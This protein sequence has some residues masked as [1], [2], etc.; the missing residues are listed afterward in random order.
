MTTKTK[1]APKP[2]VAGEGYKEL[3]RGDYRT[4]EISVGSNF[5][6]VFNEKAIRELADSIGKVGVLQPVILRRDPKHKYPVLVA[7]ERRL[8]A[9][10]LA[11]V[12]T[13]PGRILDITADQ[14]LEVQALENLHRKDLTPLEEARAFKALLDAKGHTL[15]QVEELAGR[16]DKSTTYIYRAV[17]LLE[18]PKDVLEKIETG[19]WTPAHGH[20]MLRV[21]KDKIKD[22]LEQADN[23]MYNDKTLTVHMLKE[24]I[25]EEVENNLDGAG[26]PKTVEYA[27]KP[28]CS[29]CSYNSGNQG[30]LFDGAEKGKCSDKTCFEAKEAQHQT[31][32]L[33]KVKKEHGENFLGIHKG[34][35]SSGD[36]AGGGIIIGSIDEKKTKAAQKNGAKYVM[37]EGGTIYVIS[38]DKAV[39]NAALGYTP[40]GGGS[41]GTMHATTPRQKFIRMQTYKALFEAARRT[42]QKTGLTQAHLAILAE[43]L[44]P[45]HYDTQMPLQ[46]IPVKETSRGYNS[47]YNYAAL[48][49]D[50]LRDLVL[51]FALDKSHSMSTVDPTVRDLGRFTNL[52]VNVKAVLDAGKKAGEVAWEAQKA[53]KKAANK[54]KP[55][56]KGRG[57]H[58]TDTT[59]TDGDEE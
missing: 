40:G 36:R 51:M 3:F 17:R 31:D 27:G 46:V 44:E 49:Y 18:L 34:Y 39:I 55:A 19:E 22:V 37:S 59:D 13:I 16:V 25:E 23:S 53:A 30:K 41:S 11:G 42:C 12:K 57:D 8:R 14:A 10:Q 21:P 50:E 56:K 38:N 47:S 15:E 43:R 7:G 45:G 54:T 58:A 24:A 1:T 28:A 20:L 6:K 33:E 26:F 48:T 52:G 4:S 5:R 29:T 32:T 2:V 9:A 35:C